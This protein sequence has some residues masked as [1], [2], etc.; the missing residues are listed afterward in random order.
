[1]EYAWQG[2]KC[3]PS[4]EGRRGPADWAKLVRKLRWIG[5]ED[6]A[7]CLQLA[8]L[9]VTSEEKFSLFPAPPGADR[10]ERGPGPRVA[11]FQG[12]PGSNDN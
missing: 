5:L 12:E 11:G 1:M 6:E 9:T 8:M 3:E 2:R 4:P 10:A 7:R